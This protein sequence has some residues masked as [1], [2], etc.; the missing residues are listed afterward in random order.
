MLEAEEAAE[1]RVLRRQGKTIREI[2]R[3][4]DVS[5]NTVRRADGVKLVRA[6]S[7]P[8]SINGEGSD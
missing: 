2:G 8:V 4:L 3:M 7:T 5:R 1:I 6:S